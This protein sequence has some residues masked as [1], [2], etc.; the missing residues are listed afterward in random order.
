MAE[1]QAIKTAFAADDEKS[2]AAARQI[3][4]R[5]DKT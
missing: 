4:T 3:H 2:M 5:I 1:E